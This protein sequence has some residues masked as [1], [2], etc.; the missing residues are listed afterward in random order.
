MFVFQPSW[1][2]WFLVLWYLVS[3]PIKHVFANVQLFK[4]KMHLYYIKIESHK[5]MYF[6]V[7]FL[8]HL[9]FAQ[10]ELLWSP[11]VRRPSSFNFFSVGQ[12]GW[13]FTESILSMTPPDFL[14]I[15]EIHAE[16]WFPWQWNEKKLQNSSSPKLVGRFSIML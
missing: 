1:F 14:Q 6:A 11:F 2:M 10:G 7:T 3:R 16:F 13:N 4:I 15:F 5:Y 9:S 12:L 8:A